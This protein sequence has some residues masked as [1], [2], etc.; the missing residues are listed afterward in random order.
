M[1]LLGARPEPASHGEVPELVWQSLSDIVG[2]E[3][4]EHLFDFQTLLLIA[5][6][7]LALQLLYG[8]QART[9]T[10]ATCFAFAFDWMHP[11]VRVVALWGTAGWILQFIHASYVQWLP[12]HEL[13]LL[14][15]YRMHPLDGIFA[16]LIIIVPG[17]I[18]SGDP[19]LFVY[20][21]VISKFWGH[22]QHF[23]VRSNLGWLGWIVASPQ[24]HQVHHSIE[25][26]HKARN[27][28]D[29]LVIWDLIF[30]TLERDRQVYPACGVEGH[31]SLLER[32][33]S[34]RGF[35]DPFIQQL[36]E[37]LRLIG[38]D[39]RRNWAMWNG[40]R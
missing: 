26:R 10:A 24:N 30:G 23:S 34:L 12:W 5:L 2:D 38:G 14:E 28:G 20:S 16:A 25:S 31:E 1:N 21:G 33:F 15:A 6:P 37:P 3:T 11:V 7:C 18:V 8:S 27:F 19:I 40:T 29:R 17:S 22:L 39:L 9:Q 4:L 13:R 35:V 36:I 32:D